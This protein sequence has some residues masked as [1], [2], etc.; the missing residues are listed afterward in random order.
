MAAHAQGQEPYKLALEPAA[1]STQPLG[2]CQRHAVHWSAGE[3]AENT[4]RNEDE[5]VQGIALR[6]AQLQ[7]NKHV[8]E[9]LDHS[10][11]RQRLCMYGRLHGCMHIL[12][13]YRLLSLPPLDGAPPRSAVHLILAAATY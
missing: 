12:L 3:G 8:E 6:F 7:P 1:Q 9:R 13:L 5:R 2:M 10:Q 4:R 11:Q